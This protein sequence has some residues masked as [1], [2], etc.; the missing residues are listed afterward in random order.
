M[1]RQLRGRLKSISRKGK[2]NQE[3]NIASP[4]YT[5]RNEL[6]YYLTYVYICI[7]FVR[8]KKTQRNAVTKSLPG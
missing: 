6:N 3:A 2:K 8:V 5:V 1:K 7:V 4:T